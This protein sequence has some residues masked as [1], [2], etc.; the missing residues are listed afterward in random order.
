M[1][2][3]KLSTVD[4]MALYEK[5]QLPREQVANLFQE[6]V[7]TG[8]VW[9]MDAR[10]AKTARNL[11]EAKIIELPEGSEML[12]PVKRTRIVKKAA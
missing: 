6:L 7:N 8:F 2:H 11:L 4:K 5:G 1:S 9:R 12:E 10:Y 3:E